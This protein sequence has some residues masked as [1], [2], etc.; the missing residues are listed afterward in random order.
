MNDSL[1]HDTH[2]ALVSGDRWLGFLSLVRGVWYT[3]RL[4]FENQWIG[5]WETPSKVAGDEKLLVL[6]IE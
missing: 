2:F 4:M 6:F 3:E 5:D 1:D